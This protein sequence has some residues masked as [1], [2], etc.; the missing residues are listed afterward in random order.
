MHQNETK[1]SYFMFQAP[2]TEQEWLQISND[3]DFRWQFPHCLGV[4]DGKHYYS[5]T[6]SESLLSLIHI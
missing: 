3:F 5:T 2:T 4:M 6:I 1:N